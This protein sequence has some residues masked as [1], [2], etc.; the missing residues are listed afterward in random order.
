MRKFAYRA[1]QSRKGL[2]GEEFIDLRRGEK[3]DEAI[4]LSVLIAN[5]EDRYLI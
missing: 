3:I 5:A 1:R 2:T 4:N